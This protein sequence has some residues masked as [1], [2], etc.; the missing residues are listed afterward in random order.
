MADMVYITDFLKRVEG[1]FV[2]LYIPCFLRT[3]GTANYFGGPNPGNYVAMGASGCTVGMGCDLG[4]TDANT[5]RSYGCAE[6]I[7][8]IFTPYYGKKKTAAINILHEK[9]L[10]VSQEVAEALTLVVHEGYLARNVRPAY[11]KKS[12]VKFDS[13]PKQAQAVVMSVCYQ[14]GAGGVQRDWPKTWKYL[15]TQDWA[16]AAHELKN[17]FTQYKSRRKIE[18]ELLE[19]LL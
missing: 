7:V 19:Q 12:R 11:E 17:G 6:N 10:T 15:T 14:K 13:L 1:F 4:Q 18:G 2:K 9:P 5:L 3:G 16:A 8:Q